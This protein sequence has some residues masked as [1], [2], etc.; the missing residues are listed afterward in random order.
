MQYNYSVIVPY[1][2]KYDLFVKAVD[3]VS[4]RED[5]QIIIVDNSPYALEQ[6]QIP[7]KNKAKVIYLTSLPAKGAGGARNEGLKHA[8]GKYLLFLDSDDF[9]TENA[10]SSFDKY[11][12]TEYDIIY[13]KPTSVRLSDG[14]VSG[15]HIYYSKS[16]DDYLCNGN[17]DN[18][19]FWYTVPWAKMIKTTL[20]NEHSIVFDETFASNDLMFSVKTGYYASKI[21]ASTDVV[22]VV[23]EAEENNSIDKTKTKEAQFARFSVAVSQYKFMEKVGRKDQRFSLLSYTLQSLKDFGISEF[24]RY[25][26]YARDNKANI[27][28][29]RFKFK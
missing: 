6:D 17:E 23:T 21:T 14:G 22:Y 20:V 2:D 24:L 28:V 9:F 27:F 26:R 29:N 15:R 8:E 12:N 19:R 13:F 5:I 18:L 25:M 16:V 11:L 3:S 10:F 1:R 4:D 7:C